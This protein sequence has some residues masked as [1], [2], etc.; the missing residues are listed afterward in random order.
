[1]TTK[2]AVEL[3]TA[4]LGEGTLLLVIAAIGWAIHMP[5]IFASLGPTA[6]EQVEKPHTRSARPYNVLVGHFFGLGSGFLAVYLMNAWDAPHV[7]QT[8]IITPPRIWAVV[9]AAV[10]TTLGTLALRARQP[11]ALATSILVSLGTMQTGR[12][13][14][15]IILGVLIITAIGQPLRHLRMKVMAKAVYD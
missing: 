13:A 15:A 3:T 7:L 6:Y 14:L 8:G 12:D 11:A 2:R 1:M 10:L 5:L 9:I 4:G